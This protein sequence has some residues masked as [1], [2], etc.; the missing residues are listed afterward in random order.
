MRVQY[1]LVGNCFLPFLEC[2]VCEKRFSPKSKGLR[3]AKFCCG[4]CRQKY[5]RENLKLKNS[6]VPPAERNDGKGGK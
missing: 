2:L 5:Y 4:A 1:E 3:K 6:Y